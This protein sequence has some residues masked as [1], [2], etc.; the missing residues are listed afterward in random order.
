M[1][2]AQHVAPFSAAMAAPT[3]A[4]RKT[5][6]HATLVK[7]AGLLF[8]L[9]AL[10]AIVMLPQPM[11]LSV[12]GQYM[13]GIF[14][15]AVVVWMTEAVDYAASSVILMALMTFLLGAAPD[16]VRPDHLLGTQAALSTALAGF[17]NSAVA[18]IAAS[19]VIAA[20][21]AIT[22]LDR[23]VALGVVSLIGTS[24]SRILIGIIVVMALLAFFIPTASARVACLTPIAL[25]MISALGIEKKSRVAGMLMMAI[26]Y[27][28]MIWAMGV[29][30]GAAQNV[31]AN[32]LME[33]TLHTSIP[34]IDWLV[35]GA[36]F[37][38]TMSV[39]LYFVLMRM[40]S[41]AEENAA[42]ANK[43]SG[44]E[45]PAR[46][47]PALGPMTADEKKLLVLSVALLGFWATEGKLHSFDSSSAAVA[48]VALMFVPRIGVLDWKQVQSR[49]PWGILIQLGVGVG[50]GTALLKTGA[51]A[52]LAAYVV[53][54]FGVQQLSV[55]AIL[56]VLW[57]FLI[58]IHLGFSSGA[59]MATTMIPVMMSVLQ[60]AQI[61]TIKVAGM[62]MLLTFVTSVGW[63]L[64]INGPQNMLAFGT[65]TFEA[66]DFIRVGVVL[67][68]I[69][70]AVLLLFAATYWHWLGY[71]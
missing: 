9:A 36:P 39:A 1:S 69:A 71:V 20:A 21:M 38:A 55:F 47:G 17:T 57:L 22:G 35:V 54:A 18:L 19:L 42:L 12:A 23:R 63:I 53:D 33:R 10:V 30:T 13:L 56:A 7:S 16:P 65:E 4:D 37:S 41:P 45:T 2:E 61:P 32:A 44:P 15:F 48:A 6:P 49:I 64:P 50:L 5:K 34:W 25:G 52:W 8:G 24:R 70:Y 51:A 14:V 66:R 46:L 67:T 26:A 31:Y 29:A 59:A 3:T 11:G 68:I 27:L 43:A 60:Q 58:V 40:M 28:S 62:T